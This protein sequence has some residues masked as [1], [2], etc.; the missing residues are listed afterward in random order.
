MT[1]FCSVEKVWADLLE[2]FGRFGSNSLFLNYNYFS[3]ISLYLS[4]RSYCYKN[5]LVANFKQLKGE[6]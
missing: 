1:S 3:F 2:G 4:T 5:K 6:L